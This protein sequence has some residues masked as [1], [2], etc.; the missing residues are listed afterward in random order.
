MGFPGAQAIFTPADTQSRQAFTRAPIIGL[1][2]QAKRPNAER[3]LLATGKTDAV[4][5]GVGAEGGI[6]AVEP[7]ESLR[8]SSYRGSR[9]QRCNS[10]RAYLRFT[11]FPYF[12]RKMSAK[13]SSVSNRGCALRQATGRDPWD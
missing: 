7:S 12:R 2:A 8:D 5:V 1:Q 3:R 10:R 6:L 9:G 4:I 13:I 11:R